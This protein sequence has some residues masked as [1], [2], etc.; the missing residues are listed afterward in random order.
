L[1]ALR[2]MECDIAQGYLGGRPVPEAVF[3]ATHLKKNLA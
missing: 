2:E 3:I 1:L